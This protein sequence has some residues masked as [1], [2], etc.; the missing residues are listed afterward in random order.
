MIVA[1]IRCVKA[2][3]HER[4]NKREFLARGNL[5]RV[6][7]P[8]SSLAASFSSLL[9][10]S[11]HLRIRSWQHSLRLFYLNSNRLEHVASVLC[12]FLHLQAW[13]TSISNR[14]HP[15]QKLLLCGIALPRSVLCYL[16]KKTLKKHNKN[17]KLIIM[18]KACFYNNCINSTNIIT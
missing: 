12:E 17:I 11:H 3:V 15:F 6:H 14:L 13:K 5:A 10:V 16:I 7:S 1:I 4:E 2:C 9:R 8:A 18:Q